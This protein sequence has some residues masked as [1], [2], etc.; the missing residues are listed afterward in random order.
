MLS[1]VDRLGKSPVTKLRGCHDEHAPVMR[2]KLDCM[3]RNAPENL[4]ASPV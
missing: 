3:G 4:R 1:Q 2:L